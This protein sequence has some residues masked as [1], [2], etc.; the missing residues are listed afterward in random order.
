[1]A[2]ASQPFS[3]QVRAIDKEDAKRQATPEYIMTNVSND[4]GVP[5]RTVN[6]VR[7]DA[8]QRAKS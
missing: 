8:A 7:I 2:A 1:M 4:W 5:I 3:L 6:V